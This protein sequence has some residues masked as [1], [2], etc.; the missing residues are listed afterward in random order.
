MAGDSAY[1]EVWIDVDEPIELGDFVAA[2][3][4]IS[5]QYSRYMREMYPD[6][7]EDTTIYVSEVRRGSIIA[8]LVP[9]A[10]SLIGI[11]DQALIVE[12]FVRLYWERLSPYFTVG[13]RLPDASR[14]E[15]KDFVAQIAAIARSKNGRGQI[16][17]VAYED[18]KRQVRASIKFST[19]QAVAATRELEEHREELRGAGSTTRERVLMRF[20]RSDV[21]DAELGVRSGERVIIEDISAKDM[22]LIY[23]SNLA[24]ERIKDQMRK[25]EENIYY[26]GF[27]VDVNVATMGGRP[28]AYAV[29]HVHQIIDLPKD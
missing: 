18:G 17:A 8:E 3:T 4:S 13:G 2:F 21:G 29:T 11:M 16:A 7:K 12:Q 5:S 15:L 10:A 23:G 19:Q 26:K 24:E 9:A 14:T 6:L 22:P 1:I 20:K 28:V 25:V 27:V